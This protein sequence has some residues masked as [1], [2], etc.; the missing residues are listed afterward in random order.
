MVKQCK[1]ECHTTKSPRLWYNTPHDRRSPDIFGSFWFGAGRR[2]MG[3]GVGIVFFV[4]WIIQSRGP[5][6]AGGAAHQAFT[7]LL[8]QGVCIQ[9]LS[10]RVLPRRGEACRGGGVPLCDRRFTA[11][12]IKAWAEECGLAVTESRFVRAGF[13]DEFD[14]STGK[15]ILLITKKVM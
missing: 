11:D 4:V 6:G 15:E 9:R 12:E 5:F 13:D 14:S 10:G 3:R 8:P 2:R 1:R 7:V